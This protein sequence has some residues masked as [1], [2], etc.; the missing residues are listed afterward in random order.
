MTGWT[1]SSGPASAGQD[2]EEL[3]QSQLGTFATTHSGVV[4]PSASVVGGGGGVS[5][6]RT[7]PDYLVVICQNCGSRNAILPAHEGRNMPC[8]KCQAMLDFSPAARQFADEAERRTRDFLEGDLLQYQQLNEFYISAP[9]GH[10]AMAVVYKA[11]DTV[12]E[13]DVAIKV[14]P[15]AF[16]PASSQIQRNVLGEARAASRLVHPNS[17]QTLKIG[18]GRIEESEVDQP[19]AYIAMELVSG[20]TLERL[21]QEGGALEIPLAVKVFTQAL[22]VLADAH[23]LNILHRDIKPANFLVREDGILKLADFGMATVDH[24][25]RLSRGSIAGTPAYNSPE[26]SGGGRATVKNDI[27]ML[28]VVMFEA[29]TGRRPFQANTRA[30]LLQ[31]QLTAAVPSVQQEVARLPTIAAQVIERCLSAQP[32]L[33]PSAKE[34]LEVFRHLSMRNIRRMVRL[35]DAGRK[36]VNRWPTHGEARPQPDG[37]VYMRA[38]RLRRNPFEP[39]GDLDLSCRWT[40]LRR[41]IRSLHRNLRHP[42]FLVCLSGPERSGRTT[43]SRLLGYRLKTPPLVLYGSRFGPAESLTRQLALRL[44]ERIGMEFNHE[45]DWLG[46]PRMRLES[47][48]RASSVRAESIIGDVAGL[49][50]HY[51]ASVLSADPLSVVVDDLAEGEQAEDLSGLL[52][53]TTPASLPVLVT[54]QS[55]EMLRQMRD[56]IPAGCELINV[57]MPSLEPVDVTEFLQAKLKSAGCPEALRLVTKKGAEMLC[58]EAGNSIGVLEDLLHE[59]LVLSFLPGGTRLLDEV[60]VRKVLDA[61]GSEGSAGVPGVLGA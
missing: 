32:D 7:L 26:V 6:L 49:A 30:E 35:T 57:A 17:V 21:L 44:I 37:S 48:T 41:F 20:T 27:Y 38:L 36:L 50:L 22:S 53:V 39:V 52:S 42:G 60:T 54:A 51:Q 59:C 61:R 56:R 28:G 4:E 45:L 11:H 1:G 16:F 25:P 19:F 10:G 29:L 46:P 9:I 55:G 15:P 58:A 23:A 43:T 47:R 40:S 34:A 5:E 2:S 24:D 33:R 31:M 8:R 18:E 3:S 12:L 13:R 14:F